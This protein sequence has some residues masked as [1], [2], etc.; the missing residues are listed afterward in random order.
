MEGPGSGSISSVA[1]L[2]CLS[3][4]PDPDFNHP[5]SRISDPGSKNSNKREGW[6][7]IFCHNFLCNHKFHKIENY[8]SF[9]VL[10]KK[11]WE[12]FQRILELFTQKLSQSSQKYGIRK[13]PIADP[14]VKKA[15]DPGSGSATLSISLTNGSGRPKNL[16]IRKTAMLYHIQRILLPLLLAEYQTEPATSCWPNRF[17]TR[18]LTL[19]ICSFPG[20]WS[21]SGCLQATLWIRTS[22]NAD[23]GP[24][25]WWPKIASLF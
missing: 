25:F 14:G 9:E 11:I 16:R 4:I 15:P 17:V 6:K 22:V 20:A 12:N 13:K 19:L 21:R 10:K 1:D 2:G 5:G 23:P 3:R 7:K 24:G 18:T 8:F